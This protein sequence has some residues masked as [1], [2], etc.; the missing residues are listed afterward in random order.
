MSAAVLL[1]ALVAWPLIGAALIAVLGRSGE[2]DSSSGIDARTLALGVFGLEAVLAIVL[3][4]SVHA[5][6]SAWLATADAAWIPEIGA[7]F[8][9]G[10]DSFALVMVVMSA[11][12]LPFSLLATWNEV[13]KRRP[14]YFACLSAVASGLMGVF[15]ARD[16]LL[17]YVAWELLLIPMYFVV[18]VWGGTA[19][20][21]AALK[22]FIVTT[23]GSLLMLV[24]V[25]YV[26]NAAGG[27]SF[28]Y[29]ALAAARM[30]D[31]AAR[32]CLAAFL[33]AFLVKAPLLPLHS[34]LPDAQREAP[35]MG[36]LALGLKVS[37][38]AIARVALPLF[39][40]A[41][42][43]EP[44]RGTIVALAVAG[45]IYGALLAVV[46]PDL[47]RLVSYAS[48]S[49]VGLVLLALFA[50]TPTGAQGAM[51]LMI[52]LGIT[53]SALF[54]LVGIVGAQRGTFAIES[55]GGVAT[56]APLLATAFIIV[57]MSAIGLPA[58]NGF[59]GELLSF[60]GSWRV[61]PVPTLV[62]IV[63]VV[64]AA[65]YLLS[66]MQRVVFTASADVRPF[67]DLDLRQSIAMG[68]FVLAIVWLGIGSA[69]MMRMLAPA[70]ERIAARQLPE[71][72]VNFQGDGPVALGTE[73]AR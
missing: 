10:A 72:R 63:G 33:L 58:T 39:P 67:R 25:V 47:K 20:P 16:L 45:I 41:A 28:A 31:A 64:L 71:G 2:G 23:L 24:A 11:L 56:Q 12:V 29:D 43:A 46:Q 4:V 60:L 9:L 7:R 50:F 37:T 21:R 38:F 66:A 69:P 18:G 40:A 15:L 13:A 19:A 53:T 44:M 62:A 42:L 34:W 59:I 61:Y 26:W 32:W 48:I 55:L 65:V 30:S 6:G 17:F 49:H 54:I 57:T 8:S 51:L 1:V 22:Y 14:A 36:A 70:A 27:I 35:T 5:T 68:A 3:A 52:N 73:G